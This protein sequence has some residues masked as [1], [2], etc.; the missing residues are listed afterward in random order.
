VGE[1]TGNEP[2]LKSG[3]TGDG[4]V[5]LQ[6]RLF[7]LGLYKDIP[8]ATFNMT[9]ENAVRALQSSLGQDNNGEVTRETWE[10]I[11]YFEQQ[12]GINYQYS[13]PYDALAQIRYDL[14]HPEDGGPYSQYAP[15]GNQYGRDQYGYVAPHQDYAANQYAGELSADGQWRWDGYDWQPVDGVGAYAEAA[16]PPDSYVGQLS[17]DGQWRWDGTDWQPTNDDDAGGAA[18]AYVGQLSADGYWRWDG[19]QWNAA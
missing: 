1:L 2:D 19:H 4:V 13:N 6:V 11:L 3:D 12:T 7:G 10:G 8:D 5:L 16:G 14:E 17:A 9:T 18:D 15:G